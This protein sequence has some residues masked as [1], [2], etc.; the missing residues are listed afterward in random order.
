MSRTCERQVCPG[1]TFT[2][3]QPI[4]CRTCK[5]SA[6]G[7]RKRFGARGTGR[8]SNTERPYGSCLTRRCT[9]CHRYRVLWRVWLTVHVVYARGITSYLPVSFAVRPSGG[10]WFV[11]FYTSLSERYAGVRQSHEKFVP[12][13]FRDIVTRL[14]E[15]ASE[16]HL[17]EKSRLACLAEMQRFLGQSL[18]GH[19]RLV[20]LDLDR[21]EMR[22]FHYSLVF[23]SKGLAP[24]IVYTEL[25]LFTETLVSGASQ[26]HQPL[27]TYRHGTHLDGV[28]RNSRGFLNLFSPPSG[29][30]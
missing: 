14:E 5:R 4:S 26:G 9:E 23:G 24:P 17:L 10:G 1:F 27:G 16:E 29:T 18:P 15:W 22:L 8:K 3:R 11:A 2:H 7:V 21:I 19:E 28:V 20:G 6:Y 25:F 12:V 13:E 30:E